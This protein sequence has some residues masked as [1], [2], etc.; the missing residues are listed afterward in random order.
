MSPTIRGVRGIT[1]KTTCDNLG[2]SGYMSVILCLLFRVSLLL[3][4]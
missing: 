2:G 1:V 4:S 3:S